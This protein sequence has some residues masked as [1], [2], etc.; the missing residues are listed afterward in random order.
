MKTPLALS[1]IALL[2]LAPTP[3]LAARAADVAGPCQ[4]GRGAPIP[5]ASSWYEQFK[6]YQSSGRH[7]TIPGSGA[8]EAGAVSGGLCL[9]AVT[10]DRVQIAACGSFGGDGALILPYSAIAYVVDDPRADPVNIYVA[11]LFRR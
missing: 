7:V 1:A 5:D 6:C 11:A 4:F 3:R 2:W 9:I 8:F 10:H